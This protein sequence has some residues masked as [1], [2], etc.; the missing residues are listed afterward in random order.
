M[1]ETVVGPDVELQLIDHLESLVSEPVTSGSPKDR[2]G[3]RITAVPGGGFVDVSNY[4]ALVS[5]EAWA[6][7]R[8]AAGEL[9]R[10]VCGHLEA[11][12]GFYARCSSPGYLPDPLTNT[13]RYVATVQVWTRGIP[14]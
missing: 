1:P 4:Q 7:T 3:V 6:E 14:L 5:M 10:L 13:P 9:A 11:A 12:T 2:H 8:V